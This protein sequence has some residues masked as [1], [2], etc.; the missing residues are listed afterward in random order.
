MSSWSFVTSGVPQGSVVGPVLY[1]L[2]TDSFSPCC[3]NSKVIRYADDVTIVHFLRAE[4]E[5]NLQLE[6]DNLVNWSKAHSL[7]LN[8]SKCAV[9]NFVT[10]KSLSLPD[11]S[12]S[13]G[14]F[15][16]TCSSLSLLGVLFSDNFKWNAHVQNIVKKASRRIFLI[17]NLKRAGCSSSVMY[18]AYVAFIRSVLLY[19][20]PIFCNVPSYLLTCIARVERRV[21]RIIGDDAKNCVRLAEAAENVCRRLFREIVQNVHHPLRPL[22][23]NR[24][25]TTRDRSVLKP[26]FARTVR[27]KNSFIRFGS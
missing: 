8:S 9:M 10:K 19:C 2:A 4:A 23:V 24:V 21:F 5:D 14:N 18:S 25:P 27:F 6:W 12:T 26:P 22:F 13:E 1:V 16:P 20:F 17:R 15:L 11:I 7:P 3:V